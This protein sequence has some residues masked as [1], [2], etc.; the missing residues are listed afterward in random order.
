MKTEICMCGGGY[1]AVE[2]KKDYILVILCQTQ[3]P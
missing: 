1:W 3:A 2:V